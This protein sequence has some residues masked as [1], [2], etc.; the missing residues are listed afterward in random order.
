MKIEEKLWLRRRRRRRR[1]PTRRRRRRGPITHREANVI[2][3]S[4]ER[5][6]RGSRQGN[7]FVRCR[8]DQH[9]VGVE[10]EWLKNYG[11]AS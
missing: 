5:F 9:R 10:T 6:G 1:C 8:E 11:I 4:D 2:A 3:R 7:V